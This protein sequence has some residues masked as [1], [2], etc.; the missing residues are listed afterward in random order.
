MVKKQPDGSFGIG[1]GSIWLWFKKIQLKD[2]RKT[3]AVNIRKKVVATG[4]NP[5]W[6]KTGTLYMEKEDVEGLKFELE[7]IIKTW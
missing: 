7:N 2:G 6:E 5:K 3:F 4:V 1:K